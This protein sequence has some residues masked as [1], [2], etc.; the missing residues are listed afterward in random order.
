[1]QV[2]TERG[3]TFQRFQGVL[4]AE[5]LSPTHDAT[6]TGQVLVPDCSVV[7]LRQV[8]DNK[9]GVSRGGKQTQ[10]NEVTLG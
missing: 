4:S 3:I 2:G 5:R 7:Q 1:M 9:P 6:A 8:N 10:D